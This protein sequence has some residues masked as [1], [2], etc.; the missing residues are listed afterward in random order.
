MNCPRDIAMNTGT[1]VNLTKP[2]PPKNQ[3]GGRPLGFKLAGASGIICRSNG[4]GITLTNYG[5][6]EYYCGDKL[7]CTAPSSS[8]KTPEVYL[9]T[10]ATSSARSRSVKGVRTLFVMTIWQ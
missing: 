5:N 8:A 1:V 9:V 10:C 6:Y 4:T 3:E 7:V 2:L